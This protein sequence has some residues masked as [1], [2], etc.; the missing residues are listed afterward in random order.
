M[1]QVFMTKTGFYGVGLGSMIGPILKPILEGL[2][3]YCVQPL[4][5]RPM[6]HG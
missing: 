3:Q 6:G 1:F 5:F 4:Q 2:G